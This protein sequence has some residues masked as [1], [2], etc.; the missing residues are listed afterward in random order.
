MVFGG[1]AASSQAHSLIHALQGL[2]RTPSSDAN[3]EIRSSLVFGVAVVGWWGSPAARRSLRSVPGAIQ[4]AAGMSC[5][6]IW[7]VVPHHQSRQ[8]EQLDDEKAAAALAP[9]ASSLVTRF[10]KK[11]RGGLLADT[12]P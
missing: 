9:T 10:A 2:F 12:N 1:L 8:R 6:P 5:V 7:H 11:G 4:E 3:F